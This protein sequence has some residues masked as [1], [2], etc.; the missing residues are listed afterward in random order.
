MSLN[1]DDRY[2]PDLKPAIFSKDE[3]L[4][5]RYLYE[6]NDYSDTNAAK[7]KI[8]VTDTHGNY[9]YI[10]LNDTSS[11]NYTQLNAWIAEDPTNHYIKVRGNAS[12]GN[13]I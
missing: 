10:D 7:I 13:R 1:H 5:A 4:E 11:Y 12:H 9:H 3:I 2:N 8:A 6:N